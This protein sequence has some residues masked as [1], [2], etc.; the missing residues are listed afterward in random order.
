MDENVL[1]AVLGLD[2]S[3]A[4]TVEG[5]NPFYS[6]V[7]GVLF[8]KSQTTLIQYPG[9]K[10]G[11]YAIPGSV[12]Y[13]SDYAF[14]GCAG[15]TSVTIPNSVTAIEMRTFYGC[16]SLVSITIPNSVVSIG[17]EALY[18]C[19][20]LTSVTISSSVASIGGQAF[21]GCASLRS[22]TSFT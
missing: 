11:S 10:P 3:E 19:A 18:G 16:A 13:I 22:K 9:G 14:Y 17:S 7:D 6:S 12:F 2:E 8:N 21:S 1:R 4:I 20:A 5:H 15:L